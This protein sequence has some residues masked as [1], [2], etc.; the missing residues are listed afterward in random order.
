MAVRVAPFAI[1]VAGANV[2]GAPPYVTVTA[3]RVPL[4]DRPTTS[5]RFGPVPGLNSGMFTVRALFTLALAVFLTVTVAAGLTK[6]PTLK[7]CAWTG[8]AMPA[9]KTAQTAAS[10]AIPFP[11]L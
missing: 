10:R 2:R 7:F 8:A 11:A 1:E 3:V 5:R 6:L 9:N 4:D